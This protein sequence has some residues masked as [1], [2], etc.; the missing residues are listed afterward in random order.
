MWSEA[1]KL[2]QDVWYT[3]TPCWRNP[4]YETIGEGKTIFVQLKERLF[5][6]K[7]EDNYFFLKKWRED[8]VVNS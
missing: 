1:I 2:K 3:Y 6:I 7:N 8:K 4:Q 5:V